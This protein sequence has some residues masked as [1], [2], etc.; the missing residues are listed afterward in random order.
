MQSKVGIVPACEFSDRVSE[1]GI[2]FPK[3]VTLLFVLLY[4]HMTLC[5]WLVV[6]KDGVLIRK[7][8]NE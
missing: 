6:I 4:V 7:A 1:D 8:R 2:R 5:I 3:H